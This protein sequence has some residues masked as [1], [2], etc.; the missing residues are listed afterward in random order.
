MDDRHSLRR[1]N[2]HI[3][4]L[5]D[6]QTKYDRYVYESQGFGNM[7]P[8]QISALRREVSRLV[9]AAGTALAVAGILPA[10]FPP[11][12]VGGYRMEGLENLVFLHEH[13]I[14]AEE[15]PG[16]LLVACDNALAALDETRAEEKRR[17]WDPCTRR[18]APFDLL[19]LG[20][21]GERLVRVPMRHVR[22]EQA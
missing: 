16:F 15:V 3:Q 21:L 12:A 20:V 8:P 18:I 7:T 11:L 1:L 14:A 17:R 22:E 13:T 6:F 5:Q 19:T 4:A 2:N 9:P 10:W